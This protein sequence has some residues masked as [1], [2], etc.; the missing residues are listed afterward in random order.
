MLLDRMRRWDGPFEDEC[1]RLVDRICDGGAPD[2]ARNAAWR[3]LLVQIAPH[4]EAWAAQSAVLRR[5]G[6]R[7]EDEVRSVLVGVM[8]RMSA[9]R[10]ANLHA[11][12]SQQPAPPEDDAEAA[13]VEGIVRLSRIDEI[14]T[15][16][17]A[18]ASG[19]HASEAEGTPLRGWLRA[20]TRYAVKDHV[21]QRFG[22]TTSVRVSYGLER[23]RGASAGAT[24]EQAVLAVRGVVT[25]ALDERALALEVA[26]LPGTTRPPSIDA[27]IEGAGYRISAPPDPRRSKRDLATGAERLDT[28]AEPGARPAITDAITLGRLLADVAA[29]MATFPAPMRDA[30]QMWLDDEPFERIAEA[31]GLEGAERGRALVRA[32]LARLRER[33]R[34]Q[35]PLCE[36]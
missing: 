10:F 5:C 11:Y 28:I 12:R 32:G 27:A 24:L 15:A 19:E 1:H 30:V 16:T 13:L 9:R 4:I 31:L 29:F 25:A 3:A 20:L 2:D 33:F 36:V 18:V 23:P 14:D 17:D 34:E 22:W 7:S 8:A 21:K 26:Y 35:R 6:L